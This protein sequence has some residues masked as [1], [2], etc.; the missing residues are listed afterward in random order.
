MR[1]L[2]FVALLLLVLLGPFF[3]FSAWG[4]VGFAWPPGLWLGIAA[5]PL[6]LLYML[7]PRH[8][9]RT[10]ASLLFWE[11]I[12]E[13]QRSGSPLARLERHLLL[14]LQLVALTALAYALAGPVL[15]GARRRGRSLV[16]VCDASASMLARDA[17]GGTSR[18]EA[19]RREVRSLLRGLGGRDE[20]T[21]IACD[22][23]ARTVVPWTR[24]FARVESALAELS[25]GHVGT[26]AHNGLLLAAAAAAAASGEVEVHFFGDGGGAPPGAVALEGSFTFHPVGSSDANAGLVAVALE[27]LPS[28]GDSTD[29]LPYAVFARVL[30][31]GHRPREVFVSLE[32]GEEAL[33]ARRLRLPPRAERAVTLEASLRPGPVVLRLRPAEASAEADP[34]P[35]DDAAYLLVPAERSISV[36]LHGAGPNTSLARALEAA[37][38]RIRS[39][40]GSATLSGQVYAGVVPPRLPPVDCLILAPRKP[41]DRVGLGLVRQGLVPLA[42]DREDPLL[43]YLDLRDLRVD[44]ARQLLPGPGVRVLVQGEDAQGSP[45]PLLLAWEDDAA[46]RVLVGFDPEASTWPLRA[47][48][49]IFLR[50]W[51]ERTASPTRSL[52]AGLS[53]GFAAELP[54]PFDAEA[55]EVVAPSG[56]TL[57]LPVRGGR[58][59]FPGAREVGVHEVH[60]PGG[61][62]R[63]C[64]NLCDPSESRIAPQGAEAFAAVVRSR[65]DAETRSLDVT[66]WFAMLALVVLTVEY[67][68]YHRRLA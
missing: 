48:F 56:R 7:R 6:V 59:E 41:L 30:N 62:S 23:S 16:L 27:E 66:S 3:A 44:R 22:R 60:W 28:H 2:G 38:A 49:P 13:R 4:G 33:A 32:R 65:T 17:A 34:F 20:A 43:R 39:D 40:P 14:L 11:A 53:T 37:G 67:W 45:A 31:A 29:G 68:L 54:A 24:S 58:V 1:N 26:D 21:L 42:W 36:G 19:A 12:A 47:S 15:H 50:N 8:A 35:L 61:S 46:R 52:E 9:R 25:P 18:F 55:V 64:A 51:V 63:F 10:V 5:L 57:R